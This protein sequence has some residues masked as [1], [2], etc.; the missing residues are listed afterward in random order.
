M[1]KKLNKILGYIIY[2]ITLFISPMVILAI[3]ILDRLNIRVRFV[4]LI[5]ERLG[6]F[7]SN[8]AIYLFHKNKIEEKNIKLIDFVFCQKII[9]NSFLKTLWSRKISFSNRQFSYL[10]FIILKKISIK[11]G[12]FKKFYY[13]NSTLK[14]RDI[15]HYIIK[16][17]SLISLTKEEKEIGYKFLNSIGISRDSKYVCLIARDESYL[18]NTYQNYDKKKYLYRNIDIDIFTLAATKLTEMGYYVFR[19]GKKVEKKFLASKDNEMII[20]YSFH[21][22]KSDFLDIFLGSTCFFCLS[23][24]CGYDEIP[25]IFKRPLA[26]I[27]PQISYY[28]TYNSNVMHIFR[29]YYDKENKKVLT[30]TDLI[31]K[32]ISHIKNGNEL[33][34]ENVNLLEPS[35]QDILDLVEDI[36]FYIKNSFQLNKENLELQEKFNDFYKKNFQSEKFLKFINNNT[37]QG[38]QIDDNFIGKISPTYLKKNNWL[39]N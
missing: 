14:I 25:I 12:Y 32:N 15:N 22:Q 29:K 20:D 13:E 10:M 33:E 18:Q 9:S 11:F 1:T 27:E 17:N 34:K 24:G 37:L 7:A 3:L 4:P 5:S 26:L 30:L 23:S 2:I 38:W 8:T 16:N 36:D 35:S 28:R 6:H 21:P 31:K 19:M 39:L